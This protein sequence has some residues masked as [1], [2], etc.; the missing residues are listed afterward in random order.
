MK[1][2]KYNLTEFGKVPDGVIDG[3]YFAKQNN[4]ASPQDYD[5][6]GYSN[7]WTGI[8]EFTTKSEFENYVKSF[9]TDFEDMITKEIISIQTIIDSFWSKKN[10]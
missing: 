1:I 3:G 10:D 4:N 6:I 7:S 2:I 8:Q 5:L 9:C